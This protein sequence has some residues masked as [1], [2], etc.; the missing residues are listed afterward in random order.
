M[1]TETGSTIRRQDY[2][3]YPFLIPQISLEFD[4]DPDQ[5]WLRCTMNVSRK[6]ETIGQPDLIL[7]GEE[8]SLVSIHMNGVELNDKNYSVT[9]SNLTIHEMPDEA[10]LIIVSTCRPSKNTSLSGL[11]LSGHSLFTQCEAEGFR[12]I[13]WYP[14]RPDVMSVYRVTL[15]A[16]RKSFPI[17]LSNGNLIH[18]RSLE[19]DRHEAQWHD[20]FA[21]PSYLFALVAGNFA[22][23]EHTT[24]TA[25]GREVLLQVYSDPGTENQTSWAMESLER[26]LRWDEQRFGLELDLDRFMIVAARDFNMGAMENKGLNI[27]NSAY[28]LADPETSTDANYDSIESIIGH[29]Y[30][31]NWTGNR[32]TCRDWF[33]L[34]LKEG[35]TVFRDQEFTADM[36]ARELPE[37]AAQS[38]RAIK[39]INDV[40]VLKIAQYP[41]DNGP[42]AHPIRPESYQEIGNFY[43]STVYQKG[44]EVIRMMHTLLGESVFRQGMD[45]Y[46]RRHDGQAV[47]CDD[48]VDAMQWAYQQQKPEKNLDVF[49]RWYS[50]AGTPKVRVSL[51]F[52]AEKKQCTITLSQRC[53]LV[54]V[55]KQTNLIKKPFHIPVSFGMLDENGL[56]IELSQDSKSCKTV[57]LELTEPSQSWTFENIAKR[58]T[59]SILRNFSAPV[60]IEYEY[61]D[62]ELAHLSAH[63]SNAFVRWE[64]GQ[65]LATRQMMKMAFAWRKNGDAGHADP[66]MMSS[67]RATLLDKNI[68]SGYRA[69]ALSLPAEKTIA[70][71]M[72][73]VDPLAIF[74]ARQALRKILGKAN[75]QELL[76]IFHN[77]TTPGSYSPSPV[78]VGRRSLKNL[79]LSMLM[80]AEHPEAIEL[81][82]QQFRHATNMTDR[83]AA[84]VTLALHSHSPQATESITQFYENFQ[85]AP[86]VI[87]KWFAVQS[88][89]PSTDAARIQG[90]MAH[91][92]FSM[93]NPNR[94][95]AVVFNFCFGNIAGMHAADGSGYQFW[96]DQVLALD[97]VNPEIAS[98]LAR[99]MDQWTRTVSPAKELMHAQLQRVAAHEGLSRNTLEIISKS[100][101]L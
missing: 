4:L 7:D 3:I 52:D 92:A 49:R 59:P 73:V 72:T 8:L 69:Q 24:K 31:H 28:V 60:I 84:L 100:L 89:S 79:A 94:C 15:R 62:D 9:E 13:C 74:Q 57:L 55:E 2:Q 81:T 83:F 6:K 19:N 95:R 21:K 42:M 53:E 71:R 1:R 75:S 12:K 33:Q 39:R 99:A 90:L 5:T 48:F 44:A 26:A 54:G 65:E 88:A 34:S 66:I 76:E 29:E 41:E 23:R 63:D 27:F 58:P 86:L 91:P 16:D 25:S 37:Q 64:A 35:L 46:F 98:R 93:L 67:W 40:V 43:T 22:C 50:Q 36:M 30:F 101:S 14:D 38:A 87:D 56:D 68:D 70:E 47:T 17:L 61:E 18:Q 32:V 80:A 10:E 96:A 78:P 45:E 97:K 51:D 82:S 85:H 77:Q 11:Y 20:P